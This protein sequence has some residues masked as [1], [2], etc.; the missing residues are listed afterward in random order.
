MADELHRGILL[1]GSEAWNRWRNDNPSIFPD[2]TGIN[3]GRG[4]FD[5][6]NLRDANLAGAFFGK[7]QLANADFTNAVLGSARF[8]RCSLQR[9]L[10]KEVSASHVSFF[11]SD[12][13]EGQFDGSTFWFAELDG[14]I[15][16]GA[17]LRRANLSY[18]SCTNTSFRKADLTGANLSCASFVRTGFEEASLSD[19]LVYGVSVWDARMAGASQSNLVITPENQ[20]LI[21]VDN[22]EVAQFIYLLLKNERIRDVIST[23]AKKAVL[24]LGRFSD[25]RKEILDAI[26]N[27]LRQR[28][29]LPIIFDFERSQERDFTENDQGSSRPFFV[30]DNR[31]YKSE[32]QPARTAS[33]RSRLQHPLRSYHSTG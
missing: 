1:Q 10:F 17:K 7:C 13:T 9:A 6:V 18:S 14:A 24:I 22:L 8:H 31:H 32:V 23:I 21:S 19:S 3:V 5:G 11:G 27:A 12:M 2:L 30:C 15:L 4:R 33:Y 20:P 28:D 26:A 25:D 29:Y 16:E